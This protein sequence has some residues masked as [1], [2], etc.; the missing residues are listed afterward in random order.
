[1]KKQ[2][3]RDAARD[4]FLSELRYTP[5][6]LGDDHHGE[7]QIWR[8]AGYNDTAALSFRPGNVDNCLTFSEPA[9]LDDLIL[10]LQGIAEAIE[11]DNE[12]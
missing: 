3:I 10:V 6:V 1:M 7:V 2:P 5:I 9:C 11:Q 8:H 4:Y 12:P